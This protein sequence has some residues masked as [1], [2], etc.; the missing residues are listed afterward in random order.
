MD[1]ALRI[2]VVD[3]EESVRD[4]AKDVLDI[5]GYKVELL[6]IGYDSLDLVTLT[7]LV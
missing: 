4:M 5:L 6:R 1:R 2:L 3:D 7:R